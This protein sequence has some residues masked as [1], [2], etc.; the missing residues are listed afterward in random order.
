MSPKMAQEVG[1]QV[2]GR[3][4]ESNIRA[5]TDIDA[6]GVKNEGISEALKCDCQ[7]THF[8]RDV[9]DILGGGAYDG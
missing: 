3:G 4:K 1:N 6:H 5:P 2:T 9:G 8:I 7:L